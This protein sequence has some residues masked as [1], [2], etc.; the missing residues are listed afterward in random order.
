[1]YVALLAIALGALIVACIL[2]ALE[3][4]RYQWKVTPPKAAVDPR[5]GLAL[6]QS[7]AEKAVRYPFVRSTLRAVPAERT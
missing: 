5:S 6:D 4:N 7:G 2:L 1:V 3:M